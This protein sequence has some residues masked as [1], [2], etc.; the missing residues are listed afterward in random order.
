[1]EQTANFTAVTTLNMPGNVTSSATTLTLISIA[2][3]FP[4]SFPFRIRIDDELM[5]VTAT[6]GTNQWTVTRGDGGTTAASHLDG[7]A[8]RVVLTKEAVDSIVSVQQAGVETSNR[9]ILN[10]TNATVADNSGNS[11]AD[12]T[13][14]ATQSAATSSLP[15][16]S[17]ATNQLFLPTDSPIVQRSNGSA[18]SLYGPLFPLTNPPT[19]SNWTWVN[20]GS[21]TA[22]DTT[23]GLYLQCDLVNSDNW[24][25]LVKTAPS[26]PY[27]MTA[28]FTGI[29]CGNKDSRISLIVRDS[30]SGKFVVWGV[31]YDSFNNEFKLALSQYNS[32]TSGNANVFFQRLMTV[33]PILFLRMTDDG[34]NRIYYISVDGVNWINVYSEART[35][36]MTA[37]QIGWGMNPGGSSGFPVATTLLSWTP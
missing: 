19:L 12:V 22:S 35:T 18:W 14:V 26:T 34:T 20:Q 2:S 13:T 28:A 4:S 21:A 11:S 31:N 3:P 8:V 33:F 27:T 1:M 36:W 9:R 24:R 16:A 25:M 23:A 6:P 15:S 30:A 10:F 7:A 37:N 5:K 17:A 29:L 32:P